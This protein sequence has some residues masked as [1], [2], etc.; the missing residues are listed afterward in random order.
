[1]ITSYRDKV[2]LKEHYKGQLKWLADRTILC[3]VHGSHLYGT[4][5]ATSDLD[6][7]GVA[8]PPMEYYFGHDLNFEQAE[9]NEPDMVIYSLRKY[10][11]LAAD[12]NPNIIEVLFADPSKFW[13]VD[14]AE[15]RMLYENRNLFLSKKARHTFSG[16]A[17]AQLKRIKSHRAW[18]LS[19]PVGK[20]VR[21]DYGLSETEKISSSAMGAFSSLESAGVQTPILDTNKEVMRI[22]TAERAYQT[23]L[24]QYNQYMHW[25]ET[26]NKKRAGDEATYGYDLKHALHLVRLMRMAKEILTTGE[27]I[28]TR[29]DASELLDIR[30]GK[31]TYDQLISWADSQEKEIEE[32]YVN[33]KVLPHK[34]DHDKIRKLCMDITESINARAA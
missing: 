15:G 29:P 6:V 4:N 12:C 31:W 33:S 8:V 20:P 26:R 28:V 21:S 13:I 1:M 10:V 9:Q 11:K 19:P 3:T 18:L 34:P 22:L 30:H 14:T 25:K 27:V 17:F 23:A 32:I 5:I 24:T 7:K 16:Y 2:N